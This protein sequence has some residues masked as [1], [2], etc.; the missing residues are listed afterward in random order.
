MDSRKRGGGRMFTGNETTSKERPQASFNIISDQANTS[1]R[2]EHA[3]STTDEV[4]ARFYCRRSKQ[5]HLFFVCIHPLSGEQDE[6]VRET[7]A[8][9]N[10]YL[11]QLSSRGYSTKQDV[12]D[13]PVSD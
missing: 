9:P 2:Y 7:K 11:R 13:F 3:W 5:A 4:K 1:L 10:E 8:V 6:A 12:A